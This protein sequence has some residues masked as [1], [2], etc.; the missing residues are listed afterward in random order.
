MFHDEEQE[1]EPTAIVELDDFIYDLWHQYFEPEKPITKEQ[2][3]V[4]RDKYNR[5]AKKA[6]DLAGAQRHIILTESTRWQKDDSKP[7]PKPV[8]DRSLA[9]TIINSNKQLKPKAQKMGGKSIIEQIIEL[10]KQ[11]LTNKEIVEK[12]FNKSTVNRQVC[13]YKK[14]SK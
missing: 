9:D 10:H 2:R 12:G 11:G 4:I 6:N 1:Q 3:K 14:R 8:I 13:E 5:L 7:V